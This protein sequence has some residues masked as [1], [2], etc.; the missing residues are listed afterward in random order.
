[1]LTNSVSALAP[2]ARLAQTRVLSAQTLAAAGSAATLLRHRH[3]LQQTRGFR[4]GWWGDHIDHEQRRELRRRYKAMRHRYSDAV[5]R[6]MLWEQQHTNSAEAYRRFA[7]HYW[8]PKRCFAFSR[9]RAS[10]DDLSK[11]RARGGGSTTAAETAAGTR[12][13]QNIED[14]E[15]SAWGH[16]LFRD[17]DAKPAA[18]WQSSLDDIRSFI[19]KRQEDILSEMP[20]ATTYGKSTMAASKPAP[21]KTKT[22]DKPATASSKQGNPEVDY[23]IDPITNRKVS[24]ASAKSTPDEI[25]ANPPTPGYAMYDADLPP[26]QAELRAYKNVPANDSHLDKSTLGAAVADSINFKDQALEEEQQPKYDDLDKYKPVTYNE[27]DGKPVEEPVEIGHEGYDQAEVQKY[28]PFKYNEPDGKPVDKAVELGHEGYDPEELAKYKPFHYNEPD[29]KPTTPPAEL[30][31]A[32]YDQAEVQRYQAFMWNEPHG[33]PKNEPIEL[34]HEGYDPA[35]VQS[36]QPFGYH[37]PHGQPPN[38][39][40]EKG[41]HGYNAAEVQGYKAFRYN[42]P[43]GKA[44]ETVEEATDS[45]ELGSY[46]SFHYQEPDGKPAALDDASSDGL[47]EYDMKQV[48]AEAS[49][50]AYAKVLRRLHNLTVLDGEG[51]APSGRSGGSGGSGASGSSS[52]PTSEKQAA[53]SSRNALESSMSRINAEHDAIDKLASISVKAAKNRARKQLTDAERKQAH[54]DPYSTRP[55]GLETSYAEECGGEGTAPLFVKTHKRVERAASKASVAE[56]SVYKILAYNPGMNTMDMAETSSAVPDAAS[57]MSTSEVLLRLSNPAKFFPHFAPLRAQGFEIVSGSGDVLI[58]RKVRESHSTG[59]SGSSGNNGNSSP[60]SGKEVQA[61]V[62]PST[63]VNPIDMTGKKRYVPPSTA[64]FVSPTG[65][66][67]LDLPPLHENEPAAKS[68]LPPPPPASLAATSTMPPTSPTYLSVT[69]SSATA[70]TAT[71]SAAAFSPKPF[72]SGIDVRREEPVFSGYK[73]GA[74]ANREKPSVAKRMVVG[75]TWVAGISYA[76]GV[77]SEYVKGR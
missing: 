6:K 40:E 3:V 53:T 9:Y 27:P 37:E 35:E 45:S 57:P 71:T 49:E 10:K 17:G 36:Y 11:S 33:Q 32:G 38:A 34:G 46:G 75:A 20:F 51:S 44:P 52:G 65:Y 13:G 60:P 5:N 29:G 19:A 64:N 54:A 18:N 24:K 25:A 22:T 31:H 62:M 59:S 69:T 58:F 26:T 8:Q 67:N 39:N 68:D 72:Q 50:E 74:T 77:A 76:I 48:K 47:Q 15:R 1:M 73:T 61:R 2:G 70:G 43:D 56:P 63:T 41:H 7:H 12:P 14:V 4:F 30:G 66:V 55:Q 23:V 28:K 21:A 42:E 16:F